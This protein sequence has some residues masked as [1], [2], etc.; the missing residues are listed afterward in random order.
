MRKAKDAGAHRIIATDRRWTRSRLKAT[1]GDADFGLTVLS[2]P[3]TQECPPGGRL[4]WYIVGAK[5]G[6]KWEIRLERVRNS[7]GHLHHDKNAPIGRA[8]P[9]KGVIGVTDSYEFI[10]PDVSG[11]IT[12]YLY[13]NGRLVD[14]DYNRV[15]LPGLTPLKSSR[16][17]FLIGSKPQHPESHY[18]HPALI[19]ALE[20]LADKYYQ[21]FNTPLQVNDISLPWG[22]LFDLGRDG[23]WWKSPHAEHRDGK[24]ADIRN[25]YMSPAQRK[26]FADEAKKLGLSVLAEDKPPHFHLRITATKNLL[27]AWE[28]G[29]RM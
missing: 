3:Q 20:T 18:G 8:V 13:I 22:G 11:L 7:G 16:S 17:I 21:K 10:A 25:I 9:A 29:R 26:F 1:F 12:D 2:E 28:V 27:K 4:R 15:R 14:T 24:Q 5:K 23:P 19:A 6:D